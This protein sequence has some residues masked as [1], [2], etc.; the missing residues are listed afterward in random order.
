MEQE[1]VKM[2]GESISK[3]NFGNA[4]SEAAKRLVKVADASYYLSIIPAVS[5]TLYA[6]I[7]PTS[8][9]FFKV[10][11]T[12]AAIGSVGIANLVSIYSRV[13]SKSLESMDGDNA[14]AAASE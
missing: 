3:D 4:L 9:V 5:G 11:M 12:L 10:A 8:P 13:L 2:S 7:N 6:W 14:D 1:D